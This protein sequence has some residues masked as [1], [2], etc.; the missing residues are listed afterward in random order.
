MEDDDLGPAAG[1]VDAVTVADRLTVA[2]PGYPI[3]L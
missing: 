3:R 1:P 2:N